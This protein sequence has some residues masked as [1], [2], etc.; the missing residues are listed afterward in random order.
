MFQ[1]CG[2]GDSEKEQQHTHVLLCC[3]LGERAPWWWQTWKSHVARGWTSRCGAGWLVKNGGAVGSRLC[4]SGDVGS[5]GGGDWPMLL[6]SPS[7]SFS[8]PSC[9]LRLADAI[10]E[11]FFG[12]REGSK[13]EA[14]RFLLSRRVSPR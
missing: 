14:M 10:S 11:A 4:G 3:I 6:C 7:A 2:W 13:E 1:G 8:V 12:G 9:K 5:L